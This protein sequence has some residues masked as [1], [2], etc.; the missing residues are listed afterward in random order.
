MYQNMQQTDWAYLAGLFDGD[1]GFSV[2][3][4]DRT[5]QVAMS[6]AN[7]DDAV[8]DW[9]SSTFEGN[10]HYHPNRRLKVFNF[11]KRCMK[12]V[13]SVMLTYLKVKKEEAKIVARMIENT[14]PNAQGKADRVNDA[15]ALYESVYKRNGKVSVRHGTYDRLITLKQEYKNRGTL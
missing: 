2:M 14:Y 10:V 5:P 11:S 3:M 4:P 13:V 7:N 6:I 9:L 1:G 12:V 8:I 15:L